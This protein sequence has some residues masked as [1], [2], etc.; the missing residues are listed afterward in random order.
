MEKDQFIQKLKDCPVITLIGPLFKGEMERLDHPH[1]FVDRGII[2]Q[3][4]FHQKKQSGYWDFSVGDGDSSPLELDL[5]LNPEKNFSDLSFALSLLPKN[6][7]KLN[8][9]GFLG[10]RR[11][12]EL[13]NL[14]EV[15]HSL[16]NNTLEAI[17]SLDGKILAKNGNLGVNID[18]TFSLIVFNETE[19]KLR[20]ELKYPL[21]EFTTIRPLSSHGLS[22]IGSGLINI[23]SKGPYFIFLP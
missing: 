21:L 20:G 11:D 23:E 13:I 19:I 4:D 18:G 6:L 10:G 5:T 16:L 8:L 2:F 9:L 12:H 7:K 3:K 15:H 17:V 1:I 14:G 22:N